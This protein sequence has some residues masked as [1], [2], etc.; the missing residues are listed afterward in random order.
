MK[1]QYLGHSVFYVEADEMKA[2]I[3]P[4]LPEPIQNPAYDSNT[5]AH[6]FLTHG[7]G[8]QKF[9]HRNQNHASQTK[10]LAPGDI[11]EF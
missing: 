6:I 3:D 10:I 9:S 11:C 7:H 4:F 8:D 2:A 1:L 5:L